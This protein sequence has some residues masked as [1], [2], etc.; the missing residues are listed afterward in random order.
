MLPTKFSLYYRIWH[1]ITHKGLYTIKHQQN[2]FPSHAQQSGCCNWLER[3][4]SLPSGECPFLNIWKYTIS[5]EAVEKFSTQLKNYDW[6]FF[7]WLNW[8]T[9]CQVCWSAWWVCIYP[10]LLTRGGYNT[11]SIFMWSKAGLNSV[12][13][14]IDWLPY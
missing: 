2:W 7:Q 8:Q 12:F 3:A 4:V 9:K 6:F 5:L 11:G 13:I 10:T 14:L 1:W